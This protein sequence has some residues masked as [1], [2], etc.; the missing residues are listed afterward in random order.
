[1]PKEKVLIVDDEPDVLDLCKRI[2]ESQGYDVT[3]TSNG[4]DAIEFA[5]NNSFD[6]LLTDIKMPGMTGLDIA[7][8]LKESDPNIICVTMTG[9][10][11]MDSAIKALSRLLPKI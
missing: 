1:M 8:A 10:A 2:L 4:Y 9:Y 11:T 7:Q 3:S 5:H 6:L